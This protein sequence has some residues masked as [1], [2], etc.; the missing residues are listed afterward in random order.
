MYN[1]Q[2]LWMKEFVYAFEVLRF[3]GSFSFVDGVQ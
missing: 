2:V 3:I 1:G